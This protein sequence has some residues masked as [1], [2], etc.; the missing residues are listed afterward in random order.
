MARIRTIKP[1]ILSDARTAG[2]SDASFR[3]FISAISLADDYGNLPGD[4]RWLKSQ[5][6]WAHDTPPRI[7]EILR[8]LRRA[9]LVTVYAVR[10]QTYLHLNGWT[11]HQRVDNA[12]KPLVPRPDDTEAREIVQDETT[13]ETA[14]GDSPRFAANLRDSRLDPDPDLDHDHD[15]KPPNPLSGGTPQSGRKSKRQKFSPTDSEL[16]TC[17]SVLGALSRYSGI[18]YRGSDKHNAL[19]TRQLRLGRTGLDLRKVAWYCALKLDW[20]GKDKMLP[21]LRPETLFGP[22]SIEKYLDAALTRYREEFGTDGDV[23]AP[24]SSAPLRVVNDDFQESA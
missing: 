17:R 22:E 9:N 15:P 20:K 5:I 18:Q 23:R 13:G 21:Y 7:A 1:E 19:I 12:G 8:E 4:E 11:K 3:L 14:L 6:W 24:P 2:L 10:D 16:D